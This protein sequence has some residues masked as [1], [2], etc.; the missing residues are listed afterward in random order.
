M[1]IDEFV[2]KNPKLKD[3]FTAAAFDPKSLDALVKKYIG[4]RFQEYQGYLKKADENFDKAMEIRKLVEA[5]AETKGVV[6]PT[7]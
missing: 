3:Q 2:E 4:S 7:K 5:K 1:L 6:D